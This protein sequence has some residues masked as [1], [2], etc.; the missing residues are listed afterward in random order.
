[1][2]LGLLIL[3]AALERT[4][5]TDLAGRAVLRHADDNPDR[6]LLIL[7]AASAA[8]GAFMSNTASTAFFL[9]IV[10]GIAKKSG[11]S[12]SKLLMPLAFSSI[13]SSSVTLVSTSTNMV[14]SGMITAYGMPAMGMFELAPVGIPIT[15]VGLAY[16][17]LVRRFIPDR[18]AAADLIE[19]FGVRPYL[20]EIVIQPGSNLAG[21]TLGQANVAQQLGLTVLRILRDKNQNVAV[22]ANTTLREGDTLIVE[23]RQ[24]DI[25]KI[26]DTA[27]VEIVA[28]AKVSASDL[29][30]ENTASWQRLSSCPAPH[31]SG[32]PCAESVFARATERRSSASIT[33]ELM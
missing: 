10:I 24:A 21:K 6:L 8:I 22:R 9:P 16:M 19:E 4:G 31:C 5:V 23:G 11:I 1:M 15:L 26:K 30:M 2:I 33:T 7:M 17:F 32:A 28:D 29:A 25:L 13:V 27:G 3:T 20:S 12:A 18:P 14:V